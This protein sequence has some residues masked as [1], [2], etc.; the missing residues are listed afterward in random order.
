MAERLE[1][2]GVNCFLYRRGE[3]PVPIHVYLSEKLS[4]TFTETEA[5]E[6][7]YNASLLPGVVGPVIGMPDIHTGYGLPIGG[8]MACDYET[9]IVSAGAVGMDINCGVRLLTTKIPAADVDKAVL[10]KLLEA[11]AR[12][13]PAGVG[14]VSQV[15]ELR[16]ADLEAIAAAG[17]AYFIQKGFGRR[18]DM[19]RI[20]DGGCIPGAEVAAVGK[21]ARERA[22]QL[23]TIG[24]GNHFIEIGRVAAVLEEALAAHF[25]LY[26][27]YI[28]VLIHT[29]S[30]G[31]G[32]QICTDYSNRMWANGEK[33]GVRA[34]VKGLA[35]APIHSND[36]QNYLKAMALAANYAFAN[37]Q[38]ITHF[39]REAFVEV[40]KK[41]EDNLGLDLLY[42]VA[43][44]IAKKE[45][46]GSRWL[47]IHRK[48][49]TRA[50]PAGHGD[51]PGCYLATG[52]P[53]IIPGSMGTASYVVVGTGA[54]IKTYCSVN[55]GAGRVMSR[56]K[57]RQ[58][59]S[60]EDLRR[61]LGGVVVAAR[62]INLLKDEAPLAYKDIDA[63]VATLAEAGLTK[64]VVRLEPMGVLKGEGDEA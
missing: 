21:E 5:L 52:H 46:H 56:K 43:H 49:A 35:C 13:V 64:P 62:D 60:R 20:E 38:L 2:I 12:R 18:E 4:K 44:N 51:N 45:K 63:V 50:L 8:V 22:E 37:R 3:S 26:K 15:K 23:A 41:P 47:L 42:D 19:E 34:P 32:H 36:G 25:G 55:H 17:A 33:N 9:G 14:R 40:L 61:Q 48:G 31:L 30:R 27:D 57:A 24:G 1:K 29:G 16:R 54:I 59:F 7:L 53:A 58:E 10:T 11:I 28:Y 39:V 6:Q